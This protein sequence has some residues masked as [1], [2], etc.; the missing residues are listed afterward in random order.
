MPAPMPAAMSAT[1]LLAPRRLVASAVA[2]LLALLLVLPLASGPAFADRGDAV[3]T[4]LGGSFFPF[5]RSFPRAQSERC[6]RLVDRKRGQRDNN[7]LN[8][9]DVRSLRRNGC[10]NFSFY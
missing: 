10:V 9:E 2:A 7:I 4:V 5:D 1:I 6:K 3:R 8:V